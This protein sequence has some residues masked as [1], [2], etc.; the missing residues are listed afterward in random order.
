[1]FFDKIEENEKKKVLSFVKRQ[2]GSPRKTLRAKAAQFLKKW[3]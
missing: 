1:M 2:I 3:G